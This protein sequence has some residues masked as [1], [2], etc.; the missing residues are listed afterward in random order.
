MGLKQNTHH[1]EDDTEEDKETG[2]KVGNKNTCHHQ[3]W[4][5]C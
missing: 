1:S 5:T 4:H 3:H 2:P